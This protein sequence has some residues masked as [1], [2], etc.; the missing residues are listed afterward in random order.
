MNTTIKTMG[1]AFLG[2]AIAL[3]GF[4]L[5]Q[6]KNLQVKI[7]KKQIETPFAFATPVNIP[8]DGNG[9]ALDFK[10][11]ANNSLNSVVHIN[12]QTKRRQLTQEELLFEQF[13]GG[14]RSNRSQRGSG[15]GVIIS[16][17]GY[18]VTNNHVVE[19]ADNIKV[20]LNDNREYTAKV[21]GTDP[22]TDMAVLKIEE[23]NLSPIVI[24]NSD[25]VE[26]GE[27]VLA[28]GN[29]FN[30]TS[31]V[32][33]GIV[34][35]K[36]RSI[37]IMQNDREKDIFPIESFI[38]TDAAVNPGNSGGALVNA[39]GELI[40][41]NTAIASQTG[42][43]SGYSFAVPVNIMKKVTTDMIKYGIVQRGFIGVG[44]QE[45]NQ[46]IAD[47]L[48]IES[49]EGVFVNG[50]AEGGAAEE[51]GIKKGDV[52]V[53]VNSTA[54]KSVPQLQEQIGRFN[55]GDKVNVSVL[56]DGKQREIPVTLRNYDGN[57]TLIEKPKMDNLLGSSFGLPTDSEMDR[58]RIE[59]GV[60]VEKIGKGK[61]QEIGIKKGFIITKVD[62][63]KIESVDEL[64]KQLKK[65]EKEGVLIEGIYP[66]GVKAYY[67]IGI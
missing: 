37:N 50:L 59:Y 66:N 23:L 67:G 55:P 38:Q 56:R 47:K 41:I 6:D 45:M 61:L 10:K 43:Y 65:A 5:L 64:K 57:T 19:K 48:D 3:G 2:G 54:I 51:A 28:V 22:S 31:T 14:G 53:R 30:L 7:E 63:Q 24:G 52:I 13:Y 46:E 9:G 25:D 8:G 35:A 58:L 18:I 39:K 34:S 29:P 16:E 12:T 26:V 60:K 36:G 4:S 27:W 33:A 1:I 40:G 32:T 20:I 11:A 49:A 62:K 15:S 42:S 21:I 17:D 44:I